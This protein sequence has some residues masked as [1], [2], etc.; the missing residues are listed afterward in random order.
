MISIKRKDRDCEEI[1]RK[2]LQKIQSWTAKTLGCAGRVQLVISFLHNIQ[3]YWCTIF[4][5]P[6]QVLRDIDSVLI[7]FLWSGAKL[8]TIW[9]KVSWDCSPKKKGFR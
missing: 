9:V 4:I 8:K 7:R 6:K 5:L 3:A 2:I 1:K